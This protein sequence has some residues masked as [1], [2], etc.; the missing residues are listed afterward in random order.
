MAGRAH[1]LIVDDDPIVGQTFGRMLTV[2]G[3]DATVTH[4]AQA[5]LEAAGRQLPDVILTDLRMP[6]SDGLDLITRL[7]R[8]AALREVPVAV[9]TGDHFLTE[10]FLAELRT[11]GAAIRFK[12]L[13]LNDLLSLVEGLLASGHTA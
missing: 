3:F 4:S 13:F 12:P 5:A 8:D 7:R 6:M 2:S 9:I 11:Y 1:V 10:E